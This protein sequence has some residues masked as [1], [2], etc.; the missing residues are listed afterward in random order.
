VMDVSILSMRA[1]KEGEEVK[2]VAITRTKPARGGAGYMGTCPA[3]GN[4]KRL[5]SFY[6]NGQLLWAIWCKCG[7]MQ[8]LGTTTQIEA[9]LNE[10]E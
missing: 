9:C 4:R 7:N 3:C 5:N 8:T 1:C 10:G 6:E 2:E